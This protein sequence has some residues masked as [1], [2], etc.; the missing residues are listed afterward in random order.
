MYVV[1]SEVGVMKDLFLLWSVLSFEA[2]VA[3]LAQHLDRTFY[4]GI[5][6]QLANSTNG[7]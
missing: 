7:Q 4:I 2:A 3:V 1:I 6:V 5:Y